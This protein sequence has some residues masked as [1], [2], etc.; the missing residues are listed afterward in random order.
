MRSSKSFDPTRSGR[1]AVIEEGPGDS[2]SSGNN[3]G[4]SKAGGKDAGDVEMGECPAAAAAAA[5]QHVL[6]S[7]QVC[8]QGMQARAAEGEDG[9]KTDRRAMCVEGETEGGQVS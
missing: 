1:L 8:V 3:N 7:W 6:V 2:C 5:C 9:C 4:N